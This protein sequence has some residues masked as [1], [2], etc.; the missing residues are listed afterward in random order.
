MT[1]EEKA[2]EY[3]NEKCKD[4]YMC[5]YSECKNPYEVCEKRQCRKQAYL[6]GATENGIV[7]HDLRKDT[8]DY[9]KENKLYLVSIK[10]N[11][12]AIAYFNGLHWQTKY[13]MGDFG[14]LVEE[15]IAWCEIPQFK[16]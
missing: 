4:C 1:L 7:W 11:G 5:S 8:N 10:D 16:E 2:E 12:L 9:P 3:A 14:H 6:A 15:G 13:N